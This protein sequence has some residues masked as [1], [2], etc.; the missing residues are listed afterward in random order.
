MLA[1]EPAAVLAQ[2]QSSITTGMPAASALAAA[3]GSTT[4]S[5]IQIYLAPTSIASSTTGG[6]SSERRKMSTMSIGIGTDFRS[7]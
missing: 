6:T 2:G 5:C 7:G 4:P 3:S 1:A